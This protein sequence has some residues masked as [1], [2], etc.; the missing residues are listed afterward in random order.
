MTRLEEA[1]KSTAESSTARAAEDPK[2]KP[3]AASYRKGSQKAETPE[4]MAAREKTAKDKDKAREHAAQKKSRSETD[5]ADLE[6]KKQHLANK[7]EKR[8][9]SRGPPDDQPPDDDP[10]SWKVYECKPLKVPKTK[11]AMQHD[12]IRITTEHEVVPTPDIKSHEQNIANMCTPYITQAPRKHLIFQHSGGG[13][14]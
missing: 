13:V 12:L 11:Y 10:T 8:D 2:E 6:G 3:R 7:R 5:M 9:L 4:Q 1:A 14:L